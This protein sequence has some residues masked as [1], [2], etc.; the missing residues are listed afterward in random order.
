MNA[1]A[2]PSP[3]RGAKLEALVRSYKTDC[4]PTLRERL[5]FFK[6]RPSFKE[7]VSSA[8]LAKGKGGKRLPHQRHI[9]RVALK[10][11][12]SLLTGNL[13]RL[14]SSSSF[15]KLHDQVVA[16]LKG[17]KWLGCLY[18][19]DSALHIGANLG[20]WPHKVYLHRG[21]RKGA[22]ALGLPHGDQAIK[23][24]CLPSE[25]RDLPAHE[26][27]DFLCIFKKDLPK[28]PKASGDREDAKP[29]PRLRC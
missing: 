24:D 7:A 10:K 21:T 27:E 6:F 28:P 22:K 1:C 11:A 12:H 2:K 23:V 5:D 20:K 18:Y 19:Y 8:A 16:I 17:V 29:N 9:R 26:I 15:D 14:R 3:G 13:K 4:R 25:L